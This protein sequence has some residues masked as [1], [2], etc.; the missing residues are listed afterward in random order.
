MALLI[1]GIWCLGM[2]IIRADLVCP[3][4][5]ADDS[6]FIACLE[7]V[8]SDKMLD[9]RSFPKNPSRPFSPRVCGNIC[10]DYIRQADGFDCDLRS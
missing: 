9:P 10:L 8:E 7:F 6:H 4:I 5:K 2:V 3:F 1:Y